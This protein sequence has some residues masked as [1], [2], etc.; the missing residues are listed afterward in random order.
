MGLG[1]GVQGH[2]GAGAGEQARRG[3]EAGRRGAREQGLCK[4]AGAVRSGLLRSGR[5]G[6]EGNGDEREKEK[7]KCCS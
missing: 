4:R 1:A 7:I 6:M 2:R 3:A 5:A